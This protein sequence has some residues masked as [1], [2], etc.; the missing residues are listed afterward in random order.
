MNQT[1]HTL[2]NATRVTSLE[3]SANGRI[4]ATIQQL[5]SDGT[6][7][8][9]QIVEL[10]KDSTQ[11]RA[12]TRHDKGA[13][14][15][16]LD[17][18]GRLFYMASKAD[19]AKAGSC[20][21]H[22]PQGSASPL[23]LAERPGG[24]RS[25]QVK[26]DTLF[27]QAG[28]HSQ[29]STEEEHAEYSRSRST[30]HVSGILHSAFPSRYW[31]SDLGPATDVILVAKLPR[32]IEAAA[33]EHEKNARLKKAADAASK[34]A[35]SKDSAEGK[36]SGDSKDSADSK[37]ADSLLSWRVLRMPKGRLLS[38][39]AAPNA[40]FILASIEVNVADL[41]TGTQLWRIDVATGE[42][43]MLTDVDTVPGHH[44][45]L[46]DISP[47]SAKVVVNCTRDWTPQ[48]S[49]SS[50][51]HIMDIA[52]GERTELWPD[53][54]HWV[55]PMWVTNSELAATSDDSGSGSVWFGSVTDAAP[56]RIA[57]GPGTGE[58]FTGLARVGTADRSASGD[59]AP[60]LITLRNG[61][62]VA[63][64][65]VRIELPSETAQAGSAQAVAV[66]ELANPADATDQPGRTENI[67]AT[68]E[69]GTE[70]RAWLRLP[71]GDG[72]HPLVVFAHGGPWGSWN[73]FTYRWNPAPFV[74]A[75]F[76][77]LLPDPAI[78]TGYGQAMIDR[79]QQQLGGTPYTDIM[80][81]TDAAIERSDI[82]ETKQAFAGGSY[83]GFMAN[84]VAGHTGDRFKAIVTHASL[85]NTTSMG[86]STDNASWDRA[87]REQGAQYSPHLFAEKI[88]APMLVIHGDKDYRVPIGQ[89]L[90]LWHAL[91]VHAS[92][93]R[94]ADGSLPHRYLYFPDEGH[95]IESRG[96]AEVWYRTFIGFLQEHVLGEEAEKPLSLG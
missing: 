46:V 60:A 87:M 89:G 48:Q 13:S 27:A 18:Q 77:V 74:A 41:I 22:L 4:V 91:H 61:I 42:Q 92:T 8:Q 9:S 28:M 32:D 30:M 44:L 80:A 56:Q 76:A 21:W 23:L 90:E 55:A 79:G 49:L 33:A 64:H 37:E 29:A 93:P 65:P 78:S 25:L 68:A 26:K 31:A 47:D 2:L 15:P 88:T 52:S 69:D 24:F 3:A 53:L 54:D 73:A 20:V 66:E 96:N 81:L 86:R 58:V 5:D 19:D 62:A 11:P 6:G 7:W 59:E 40:S 36:D 39:M 35:V 57:G 38:W 12:L 67:T 43:T 84:W 34:D 82:D 51:S 16:I 70:I 10:P 95:W 94:A 63:P 14:S 45:G 50:S 71:E 75:G 85:W 83:G 72:P 1:L 17:A